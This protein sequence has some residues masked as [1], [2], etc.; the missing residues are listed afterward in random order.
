MKN[1]CLKTKRVDLSNSEIRQQINSAKREKQFN[2][3]LNDVESDVMFTKYVPSDVEFI[4]QVSLHPSKRLKRNFAAKLKKIRSPLHPRERLKQ[5]VAK[6]ED[7]LKFIKVVRS[8]PR[9]RLKR[10]TKALE[11]ELIF[12]KQIPSYPRD[13]S[14]RKVKELE[15]EMKFIKQV[16]SHPRE[17]FKHKVAVFSKEKK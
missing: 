15:D 1:E 12:V 2:K 17:R 6:L 5:K 9:D 10:R 11:D 7:K 8:N 4:K 16:P 14:K 13:R 3:I